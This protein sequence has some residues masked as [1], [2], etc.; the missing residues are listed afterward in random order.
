MKTH[1]SGPGSEVFWAR[2]HK[3]ENK[4]A[5]DLVYIAG[6]ALQDHERRVLQMIEIASDK[7]DGPK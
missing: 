2:I 7:R 1:Y 3:I 5:R 4:A 6:C